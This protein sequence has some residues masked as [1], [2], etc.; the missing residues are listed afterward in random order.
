MSTHLPIHQRRGTCHTRGWVGA[1]LF[2]TDGRPLPTQL[3]RE[4]RPAPTLTL[5]HNATARGMVRL[6]AARRLFRS[7]LSRSSSRGYIPGAVD[8]IG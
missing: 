1:Q 4:D 3:S 7:R 8:C 6:T 5:A 2:G